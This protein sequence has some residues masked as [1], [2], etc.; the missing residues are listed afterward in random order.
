[1]GEN[2]GY[3]EVLRSILRL[4]YSISI[5][6]IAFVMQE[7]NGWFQSFNFQKRR[8]VKDSK[9]NILQIMQ[10]KGR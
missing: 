8:A 7:N 4:H 10:K 3:L 5:V 9:Q 1:M 2:I 6:S